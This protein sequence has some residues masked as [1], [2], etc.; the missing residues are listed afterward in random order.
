[1]R[2]YTQKTFGSTAEL[3]RVQLQNRGMKD[4]IHNII[5]LAAVVIALLT[6]AASAHNGPV[7]LAEF[8]RAG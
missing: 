7:E 4:S 8:G 1:M 6:S 3:L 2:D 5:F